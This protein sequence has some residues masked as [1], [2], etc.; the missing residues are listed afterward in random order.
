MGQLEKYLSSINHNIID[1][2]IDFG[3]K[4]IKLQPATHPKYKY[5]D[6][7]LYRIQSSLFHLSLISHVKNLG[8]NRLADNEDDRNPALLM[9]IVREVYFSFEDLIYSLISQIDYLG[10]LIGYIYLG[11]HKGTLKW[12]GIAKLC[13]DCNHITINESLKQAIINEDRRLFNHLYKYRSNLIHYKSDGSEAIHKEQLY[14]N[15]IEHTLIIKCPEQLQLIMK[16]LKFE[17][18]NDI[19][20]IASLLTEEV[21]KTMEVIIALIAKDIVPKNKVN[22]E[23]LVKEFEE[24]NRKI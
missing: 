7:L 2:F 18:N 5:R 17:C 16:N 1:I 20:Q 15:A 24:K 22:M 21:F 23:R 11:E 4:S 3:K 13:R 9:Q 8:I 14:Q 12:N 6:N 10:N 19:L